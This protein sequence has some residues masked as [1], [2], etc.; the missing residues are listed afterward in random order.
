M[1]ETILVNTLVLRLRPTCEGFGT[2]NKK[3]KT[4]TLAMM[5]AGYMKLRVQ[6][7]DI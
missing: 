2:R 5:A 1:I 4:P 3:I 6:S 7:C